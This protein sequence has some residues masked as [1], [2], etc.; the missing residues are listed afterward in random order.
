M[1]LL[2]QLEMTVFVILT[3]LNR[4][5]FVN[6]EKT[7]IFNEKLQALTTSSELRRL[8]FK[9][10]PVYVIIKQHFISC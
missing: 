4:D 5:Y 6:T 2:Q 9:I 8:Q 3:N 10:L 1:H 7:Y